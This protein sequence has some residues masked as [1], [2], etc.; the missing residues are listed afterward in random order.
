MFHSVSILLSA[1][2]LLAPAFMATAM[3][4]RPCNNGPNGKADHNN[5]VSSYGPAVIVHHP[6]PDGSE[7][8]V[9]V[10]IVISD[11]APA[12]IVDGLEKRGEIV[13]CGGCPSQAF[14]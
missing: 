3:P 14:A 8:P 12:V 7:L 6:S 4:C 9:Q 2:L 13:E 10:E 1:L 5:G 11:S